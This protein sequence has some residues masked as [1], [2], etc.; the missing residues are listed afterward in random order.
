MKK[1]YGVEQSSYGHCYRWVFTEEALCDN[2]IGEDEIVDSPADISFPLSGS[3]ASATS[4]VELKDDAAVKAF[5]LSDYT[6]EYE[7][8]MLVDI[9]EGIV[10]ISSDEG[11][12]T[13]RYIKKFGITELT[14]P[15]GLK[16]DALAMIR[17]IEK[18]GSACK[19]DFI[20]PFYGD[21]REMR[22]SELC[23]LFKEW[24]SVMLIRASDMALDELDFYMDLL[25]MGINVSI[26]RR[27][28]SEETAAHM[29]E[30]CSSHGLI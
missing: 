16:E 10:T 5:L 27:Y 26:V 3:N 22:Y 15:N 11:S 19:I 18:M 17:F 12:V 14:R 9:A 24:F 25:S 1:L 6:T 13:E 7:D 28:V 21:S 20:N 4:F 30:F 23:Y 2:G 29:E 8:P